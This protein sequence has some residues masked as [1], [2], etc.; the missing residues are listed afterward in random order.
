M[1]LPLVVLDKKGGNIKE[2]WQSKFSNE[3]PQNIRNILSNVA[4]GETL[5]NRKLQ[6]L[7][8]TFYITNYD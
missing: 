2:T 7:M 5:G 4:S 6:L 3:A 8:H 1:M